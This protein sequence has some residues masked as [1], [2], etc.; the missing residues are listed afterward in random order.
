MTETP[1]L[2]TR[3]PYNRAM[4]ATLQIWHNRD[5][6]LMERIGAGLRALDHPAGCRSEE[7][8]RGYAHAHQVMDVHAY[9]RCPRYDLAVSYTQQARP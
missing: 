4:A 3:V 5:R 2:P 1:P 6:G 9:H 7:P 8:M